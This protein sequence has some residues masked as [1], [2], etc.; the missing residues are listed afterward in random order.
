MCT[1]H[2]Q[3]TLGDTMEFE[4]I[5]VGDVV[6]T[7]RAIYNGDYTVVAVNGNNIILDV[8]EQTDSCWSTLD[9]D[10]LWAVGLE[11]IVKVVDPEEDLIV[12][13]ALE[14]GEKFQAEGI[15]SIT[16]LKLNDSYYVVLGS[17]LRRQWYRPSHWKVRLVD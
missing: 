10:T 16:Y 17:S 13:G 2:V 1:N 14:A 4:D 9:K 3:D 7:K 5:K 15:N 6:T 8:R 11:N 12:W